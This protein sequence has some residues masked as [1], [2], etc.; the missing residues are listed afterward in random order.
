LKRFYLVL[1]CFLVHLFGVGYGYAQTDSLF[2]QLDVLIAEEDTYIDQKLEDI[3]TLRAQLHS[4]KDQMEYFNTL[5]GLW[6]EYSSFQFDSAFQYAQRMIHTA[7]GINDEKLVS[8]ARLCMIFVFRSAGLYKE[9]F[10]TLQTIRSGDLP[11]IQAISY[12]EAMGRTYYDLSYFDG[13]E[14]FVEKYG[15]LGNVYIDSAIQLCD[16]SML[17]YYR[18]SGLRAQANGDHREAAF[19]FHQMIDKFEISQHQYAMAYYSLGKINEALGDRQE[20]VDMIIRSAIADIKSATREAVATFELAGLMYQRGNVQA[21]SRYI[22]Q[23]A[24]NAEFYGAKQRV[25]QVSTLLPLI[26]SAKLLDERSRSKKLMSYL[27]VVSILAF[28]IV[29]FVFIILRQYR[30]LQETKRNL[31]LAYDNLSDLNDKLLESNTIKEEYVGHSFA[32]DS[33][34]LQKL[35]KFKKSISKKIIEKKYDDLRYTLK[36]FDLESETERL[37]RQF[38]EIFLRLFPNFIT[39]FNSFFEEDNQFRVGEKDP[40]PTELRIFALIRIGIT[41]HEQIASI[42]GYSVRTIYNYK[43][44][45][46]GLSKLS[47][48]EFETRLMDIKTFE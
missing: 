10:D 7:G 8:E 40:L 4:A 24:R 23:A 38:D 11:M 42:L 35:D 29:V 15:K 43:N 36:Q 45:V 18:L 3:A 2:R 14:H 33:E 26:E 31:S 21:A 25:I 16:K 19:H 22:H 39:Y 1:T 20:Y 13:V 17:D 30:R 27:I 44:K 6:F 46:K 32:K 12:Y 37:N 9:A 28:L 48:E 41:E 5:Y 47:K 34:Y